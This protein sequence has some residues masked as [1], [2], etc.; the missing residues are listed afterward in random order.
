MLEHIHHGSIIFEKVDTT[1]GGISTLWIYD[2]T[3]LSKPFYDKVLLAYRNNHIYSVSYKMSL[4]FVKA[5]L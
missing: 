4:H 5:I 3:I 2:L 1:V